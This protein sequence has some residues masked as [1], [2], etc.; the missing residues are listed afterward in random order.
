MKHK[1]RWI[2]RQSHGL[3]IQDLSHYGTIGTFCLLMGLYSFPMSITAQSRNDRLNIADPIGLE[4]T[5]DVEQMK[6]SPTLSVQQAVKGRSSG[7]YVQEL[8]GEPGTNQYMF[9][10][11][12]S[13]P[14]L[15]K[16][17]AMGTQPVVYVNGVP[18]ISDRNF[19]Y[20]IKNNDVNPIGPSNNILAGLDISNI[21]SIE[22][23]KDPVQLA[24]LGPLAANG[25]IWIIT[26]N[27][28]SGGRHFSIDAQL[29]VVM[30]KRNVRMTNGWDELNFRKSFYPNLSQA[31]FNKTLPSWLQDT[32]D[33]YFFGPGSWADD[34]YSTALQ[35]NVNAT[36]GGGGKTANYLATVGATT[37]M[38]GADDTGYG[39]YN[40]GFYLNIAPFTGAAFNAMIRYAYASRDRN[41]TL[42][43]R[44]AEIEYMPEMIT[45][46]VPTTDL[47]NIYKEYS[48]N[49]IDDNTSKSLNGVLAFQYK[50]HGIHANLAV[51]ADYESGYRRAFWASTMM[52]GVN[53]V[54]IYSGYDRR[55]L[56]EASVGYDWKI[57]DNHDLDVTLKGVM[58]EDYWHYNYSKG[59]D[60]DDDKKPT[61]SGG[62]YTQYRYLDEEK[63]HT[64][65]TSLAF[66]YK[67]IDYFT[68]S[69]ILRADASSNVHK[70]HKWLF[71]PAF[72]ATVRL[73]NIFLK[74]SKWLDALNLKASWSRIGKLLESDRFSVGSIYTSE[75][76]GWTGSPIVGSINGLATLTRPYSFGWVGFGSEWPYSDK[77][78]IGLNGK[79]W[80]NRVRASVAFYLNKDK[81][82]MCP[83]PVNHE[84]GY[85]YTYRQGMDISNRG[86]ELDFGIRPIQNLSG[87]TWDIDLNLAYNKNRLD[88]LP[89]GVDN[90][91]VNGRMLQIGK[92]VDQFY[93]LENKG[94]Y[95][96]VSQIPNVNGK[97]L[98][99]NGISFN[100]GDPIW[101]DKDGDNEIT[102][103]DKVL[104]GNAMPKVFGGLSTTLRYKRFDL[105]VELFGAFG[106]KALNYRT[107]QTYDF[108]NLDQ[109][110]GL[111]AIR[112]IH[113]WQ[114]GLVPDNLPRYNQESGV[115]PY[116]YDQ[117]M[118]L[119]NASYVKLRNVTLG[120]RLPL[121]KIG[122]Y[123]Y[124]S[125]NNLLTFTGFSGEDPEAIDSDGI[126]RGYGLSIPKNVTLGFKCNF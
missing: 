93:V 83:M 109:S 79:F 94:I 82:M 37:N 53:F 22:V 70:N 110:T 97:N 73:K 39:K 44:Y 102:D 61:T 35:Y 42:R 26:K 16:T 105:Q 72:G 111:D 88:R 124:V 75:S 119:E 80:N 67:F 123:I 2:D 101:N 32:S 25:A 20:A 41:T 69:A 90:M 46:I 30:P 54:S 87:W 76:L 68:L 24:K 125:G 13:S 116:R 81:N 91:K 78:E 62:N 63:L 52:G 19:V 71:S 118:Y 108:A 49:T 121:K 15:T 66:D 17:S 92:A 43:D 5:V 122:F 100:V 85:E 18:F 31:D 98:S 114:T 27:G 120:Y 99:V 96:E 86:V 23:I 89:G 7:T 40:V 38:A 33:P 6:K 84:F 106:H 14:L 28:Y 48:G 21:Q 51:K 74:E 95:T 117:D 57:S 104:K 115:N 10:R 8:T 77:F 29:G 3:T 113:F 56:G 65:Q 47:Y 11:G 58:Q 107:Y 36:L 126:Y 60:G 103:N 34:Y 55:F 50:R 4:E 64:L 45:P 59:L 12:T 112:E 1:E 9:I